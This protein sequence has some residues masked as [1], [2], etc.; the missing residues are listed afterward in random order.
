MIRCL[1]IIT[2]AFSLMFSIESFAQFSVASYFSDNM[3]LQR[4]QKNKI[5]GHT[6]K[7]NV[8]TVEIDGQKTTARADKTGKWLAELPALCAGGPYTIQIADKKTKHTL[9][10]VMIGDVWLCSGQSNMEYAVANFPWGEKEATEA[11]NQMIR[12]IDIPN[13]IEEIPVDTLPKTVKWNIATNQALKKLSA[14]AYWFAHNVQTEINVPVGLITS[15]WSGSAIEPWMPLKAIEDMPQFNEVVKYLTKDPKAHKQ[16]EEE[17]QQYLANEWGPKYFYKG[18]GMDEKW[19]D[20]ST[21]YS[22]WQAIDLPTWWEK[23]GIYE[24][25]NHDGAVWFR[26][27][28]DL[29]ADFTD[30]TYF[31]DLN[32]IKDYD[33][34]WV[35][36]VKL[37]ETFGDQNWRHYIALANILKEKENSLVV[38][39]YNMEGYGG[40]NFHPLWATPILNGDWVCKKGIE[41]DSDTIPKPRIVNKSPYGYPTAIYNAMINPILDFQIKGAIWYQGESNVGRAEEYKNIFPAMIKGWRDAFDQGDFP[42][43]FVQLANLDPESMEPVNSD[44][45]ELREAQESVLTL[46]NTGMAMAIGEVY[47]IHPANKME[48]GRRLALQALNKTYKKQIVA[49]S[50]RIKELV[51]KDETIILTIDTFGDS[52]VCTN[53]YGYING[54]AVAD[55]SGK[56]LWAKAEL[57]DGKIFVHSDKVK[58]PVYIR[59]AWSRN[60]GEINLYNKNNLPLRPYRND[61]LPGITNGRKFDLNNVFF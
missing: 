19:Y 26:T 13:N 32:L 1:Y 34:V 40:L 7:G 58:K 18:I 44:W 30:S 29:P 57:K 6:S 8:I 16:I 50:P 25:K 9:H 24:L 33:I 31:I 55:S 56:F 36:G 61:N 14:V 12:Y 39:V 45:A 54:F 43:Y 49:E 41:I 21:D 42:F 53:K 15:D 28:F 35:N 38:R 23:S 10:D 46:P 51:I 59:Y 47:D 3:V 17:F 11:T 27:S 20:Q 4:E 22:K 48:V 2:I 37:G 52:L 5:W 60:P